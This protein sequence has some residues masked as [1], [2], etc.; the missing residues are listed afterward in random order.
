MT[1]FKRQEKNVENFN[2]FH[3]YIMKFG[4]RFQEV[5][6]F[7]YLALVKTEKGDSPVK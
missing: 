6:K 1:S 3:L 7:Y 2:C 5:V 4:I